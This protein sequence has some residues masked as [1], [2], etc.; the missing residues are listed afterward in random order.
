[1]T[2]IVGIISGDGL[3]RN[4]ATL[5]RMVKPLRRNARFGVDQGVGNQAALG[6]VSL[7]GQGPRIIEQLGVTLAFFGQLF[8]DSLPPG[9]SLPRFLLDCYQQRG[10]EALCRLNGTYTIAVWDEPLGRLSLLNDR[11]G[12]CRMYYWQSPTRLLFASEYKAI[13]WHPQFNKAVDPVAAADLFLYQFPAENRTLFRDIRALTPA[14]LLTYQEGQLTI[15]TYWEPPFY[16]SGK[17]QKSDAEYADGL[18]GCLRSA[19]KRRARAGTALL[20]TGGLDSRTVG[21]IFQSTAPDIPLVT[22]TIG[23]ST[24][25]DVILGAQVARSLGF[26]HQVIPINGLYLHQY[27]AP[28]TW[29]AEGATGAYASWILAQADYLQAHDLPFV[30][31]GLWGNFISGR[32]YPEGLAGARTLDQAAQATWPFYGPFIAGLKEL[33]RPE[34]FDQAAPASIAATDGAYRRTSAEDFLQRFDQVFLSTRIGRMGNTADATGDVAWALDP[35]VDNEVLD[36]TIG[37]IP[38]RVRARP[39]FYLDLILRNIPAVTRVKYGRAGMSIQADR[40]I[41]QYPALAW[42]ALHAQYFL[43]RVFPGSFGKEAR[44]S[45]PHARAIRAESRAFVQQM[46]ARSEY[47]DDLFNGPAVL[48]MLEDHILGKRNAYY[49]LDA[50]LT[51]VLW[52]AQFCAL[53]GPLTG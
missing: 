51:F 31:T 5:E 18:A 16:T 28:L 48:K 43:K 29:M 17:P 11:T 50:V 41:Q 26:P 49:P 2:G 21:G 30:M 8:E 7:M 15:R 27:S 12:Y 10:P 38:P 46:L 4:Q 19:V 25:E 52:R 14:S 35:F 23:V 22:N 42:T 36:F 9:I 1:M 33:M 32:H 3:E 13:S 37:Q 47:I 24:G 6:V 40:R 44:S 39:T 45:I 20:I 34:V 53:D